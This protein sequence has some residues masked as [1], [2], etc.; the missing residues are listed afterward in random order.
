MSINIYIARGIMACMRNADREAN[1]RTGEPSEELSERPH[2]DGCEH[3]IIVGIGQ[4]EAVKSAESITW[5]YD[6]PTGF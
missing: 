2:S 4:R 5:R 3:Q 6:V 1:R